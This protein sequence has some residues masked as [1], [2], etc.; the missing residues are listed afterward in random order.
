MILASFKCFFQ[1]NWG[2][3]L[4]FDGKLSFKAVLDD[5]WPF[6]YVIVH[7]STDTENLWFANNVCFAVFLTTIS[8][9]MTINPPKT[10]FWDK[11]YCKITFRLTGV[12]FPFIPEICEFC[13][14]QRGRLPLGAILGN[15]TSSGWLHHRISYRQ[16][17]PKEDFEPCGVEVWTT[18][19]RGTG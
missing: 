4:L 6:W 16:V 7:I 17:C 13:H 8:P 12:C 18:Q 14:F 9:K 11:I 2:P 5:I 3:K 10:S 1:E 15:L 19:A